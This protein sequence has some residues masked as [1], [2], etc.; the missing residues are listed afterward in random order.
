[1]PGSEKGAPLSV[2]VA[3]LTRAVS[4]TS[5][6]VVRSSTRLFGIKSEDHAGE[7]KLHL[8][9]KVGGTKSPDVQSGVRAIVV[10]ECR[11]GARD[12]PDRSIATVECDFALDYV[13]Q[14]KDLFAR[15]TDEDCL[16]FAQTSGVYNAWP[17]LREFCQSASARMGTPT[18][19]VLPTLPPPA[20]TRTEPEQPTTSTSNS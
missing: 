5:V 4:L 9:I 16:A 19:V 1:M 18:L 15:V 8:E 2:N 12:E 6:R 17:Y 10:L 11:L 13:V 14:D 7:L 20:A 3:A